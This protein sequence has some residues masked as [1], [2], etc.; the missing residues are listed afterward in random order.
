MIGYVTLGTNDLHGVHVAIQGVGSVGGGLARYLAAEGAKLTLADVDAQRA[1]DLARELGGQSV[2]AD[3]IMT[4]EADVFS[5]CALGAV[6]TQASV[7]ALK[8]RAVAGGA[9]NQLATGH[10]G[11]M[12]ADRGI[13]YAP[14]YVINA[15]GIINVLRHIENADD[16]EI[17]RRIDVIAGRL[18]A[19]WNESVSTG[20]TPA[21]VADNMAQKLIGR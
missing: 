20:K 3:A 15:G 9:N 7:A 16:A 5:P 19:I 13:L 12:L 10:E 17:N 14:D 18:A 2:A 21:E 4:V 8:V 11:R 6:L 1:A